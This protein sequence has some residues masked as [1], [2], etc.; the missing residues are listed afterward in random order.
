[1]SLQFETTDLDSVDPAY[2]EYYVPSDNGFRL[3]VSG[4]KSRDELLEDIKAE[5]AAKKLALD[6]FS[7]LER[8]E[9]ERVRETPPIA[10]PE[11]V[12][13]H[14]RDVELEAEHVRKVAE[15]EAGLQAQVTSLRADRDEA[16]LGRVS[17][18]IAGKLSIPGS[19]EVLLPHIRERLTV[20]DAGGVFTVTAR[21]VASLEHLAESF[22]SD[23]RFARLIVG[24]SP[25]D[26]V[27]HQQRVNE[28]LGFTAAPVAVTR[29]QF[30]AM[31]P[32]ARSQFARNGGKISDA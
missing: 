4:M 12:P 32:A 9:R 18:E 24:A 2:R 11:P 3:D 25:A 20:S 29:A 17:H 16:A 7:R 15:Y 26:Q 1:M 27:R 30:A 22:R 5:R 10:E 14:P 13:R 23:A 19:S 28:S 21:D 6:R 8:Q 31:T